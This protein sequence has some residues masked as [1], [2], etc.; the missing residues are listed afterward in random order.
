[1][2]PKVKRTKTAEQ[3][4]S[5]LMQLCA[6]AERSSGD[7]LRLMRNCCELF[8]RFLHVAY[9]NLLLI[10]EMLSS[11]LLY[12]YTMICLCTVDRGMS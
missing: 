3:A 1:M 12:E 2:E 8:L 10:Y 6:R 7:A 11:I 4:A 9:I 5:S